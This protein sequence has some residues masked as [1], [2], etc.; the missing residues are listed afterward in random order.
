MD[1]NVVSSSPDS[2]YPV[3]DISKPLYSTKDRPTSLWSVYQKNKDSRPT[4]GQV[5]VQN[6]NEEENNESTEQAD[7]ED[8]SATEGYNVA[9][10]MSYATVDD[11]ENNEEVENE[12]NDEVDE[13]TRTSSS[14]SKVLSYAQPALPAY[15]H[16]EI[17]IHSFGKELTT[18]TSK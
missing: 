13:V 12:S 15:P 1:Q 18:T 10:I 5:N 9:S 3:I 6:N 16:G 17:K 7:I 11:T 4:W 2:E 14:I 8:E